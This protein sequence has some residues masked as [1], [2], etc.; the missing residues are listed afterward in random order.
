MNI[1]IIAIG[2]TGDVY[3]AIALGLG[4]REEG[5]EVN[6]AANT[7]F[8]DEIKSRGLGFFPVQAMFR[9][10]LSDDFTW[11]KLYKKLDPVNF[12]KLRKSKLLPVM[13]RIV[14]DIRYA[15]QHSDTVFYNIL[16]LPAYYFAR[17]LGVPAFP[18]YLQPLSRTNRFPS[19]VFFSQLKIPST[20]NKTSYYISE[21][22]LSHFFNK[23]SYLKRKIS[24]HDYFKELARVNTPVLHGFSPA[25]SPKP[26]DWGSNMHI[27]GYWF[28]D[29]NK[30]W[31]PPKALE[32]FLN[33]G[34]P[35]VCINFGSMS[36]PEIDWIIETIVSAVLKTERRVILLTGWSG[37]EKKKMFSSNIYIDNYIPHS[38]LFPR[39]C[40]V[41]HH[42]GAGTTAAAVR[43]GVPS[44][45]VP[46][47][48]D[49]WFWG[50]RLKSLGAG[51]RPISKK[52]LKKET[53]S[54]LISNTL[55]N[56][57][58]YKKLEV[59][60]HQ[61]KNESGVYKAVQLFNKFIA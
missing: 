7:L 14:C 60:S 47:F 36:D 6:L 39:V 34:S 37:I 13:D 30:D 28:L 49:Q 48:F 26:D 55:D 9:Q 53:L 15:C 4:F 35:P 17:E 42:G 52:E 31:T 41:I 8:K 20:F 45:I 40:G 24:F 50:N 29:H 1:T 56:T 10:S 23:S 57:M 21:E 25:L 38:W 51:A 19:P 2:S 12:L 44:I 33:N 54:Y 59:L 22:L 32:H 61:V 3:P 58:F 46:F 43:A 11:S 16:A 27:T 5:H 18:I